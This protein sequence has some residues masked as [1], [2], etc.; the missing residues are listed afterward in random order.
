MIHR[1]TSA[2]LAGV[3]VATLLAAPTAARTRTKGCGGQSVET[4]DV[5]T[6][7]NKT[8]YRPGE[9]LIVDVTVMRPARKDP[10]GLGVPIEPLF[11]TPVEEAKVVVSFTVGVPPVFGLGVTDADGKLRLKIPLN[12]KVRGPIASTTRAWKIYGEGAPDCFT[13]EE[14][15]RLQ[16]YP[17]FEIR[18]D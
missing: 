12:T 16:E 15:G 14:W 9:T 18:E 5:T 17:A 8:V 1:K 10:L 4:Y 6:K 13:V 11:Q 2:I 7:W 3:L